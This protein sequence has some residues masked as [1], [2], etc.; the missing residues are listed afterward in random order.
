[1]DKINDINNA[2]VP[3]P[4]YRFNKNIAAIILKA[5]DIVPNQ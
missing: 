3:A 2:I 1:M 4:E 5:E